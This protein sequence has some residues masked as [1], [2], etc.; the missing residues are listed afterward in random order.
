[1]N[2]VM[3]S[4]YYGVPMVVIPQQGEQA[5]TAQRIA[6]MGLGLTLEK[7]AVNVITL[8]E[9][10]EQVAHDPAC[11]ERVQHMCQITHEAGGYQRAAEAIIQF[12]KSRQEARLPLGDGRNAE[13]L[14]GAWVVGQCSIF[15]ICSFL[16][17][18]PLKS[19]VDLRYENG[20]DS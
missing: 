5:L 15:F 11:R 3:E 13:S 8:R 16:V 14:E 18:L 2:S 12:T 10:V 20:Y 4:L 6:E 19:M 9:A 7:E 1:M 17:D